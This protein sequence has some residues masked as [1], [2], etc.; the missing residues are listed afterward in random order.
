LKRTFWSAIGEWTQVR[1][2]AGKAYFLRPGEGKAL[3]IR[4]AERSL[5]LVDGKFVWF[6]HSDDQHCTRCRKKRDDWRKPIAFL[7]KSE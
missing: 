4:E 6:M 2:G 1:V 7:T 5:F 3:G